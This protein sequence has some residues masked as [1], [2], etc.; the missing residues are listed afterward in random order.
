MKKIDEAKE[1]LK[2]FGL[3][4]SQ[5]NDIS[6]FTLLALCNLRPTDNWIKASKTSLKITK[7]IM[8]FVKAVYKK[9]YA[10]NTRETFRRQVLHQFVQA[11]IA[12]YNPDNLN[13][14]VNSPN[15]HYALTDSAL[16]VI[17]S[18]KS[19]NWNKEFKK[20]NST[21]ESLLKDY[22]KSRK[23]TLIPVKLSNG[24]TLKLSA[25]KHN[26]VQEAVIRLFATRFAPKSE[27]IYIGD[28]ALKDLY[29]DEKLLKKLNIPIN[30]HSKL[31]DIIIYNSKNNWIYLIEAVTSHGPISPKR[32]Y[33]LE[34]L[35]K[36]CNSA[37]IFVTAF[38][39]FSEFKKHTTNIAWETEV[40]IVDF[41]DH[42][43]HF[44]GDRF[45][46]PR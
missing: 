45:F 39:D 40:W 31:P 21:K 30:K 14:P 19:K 4:I 9:N 15:A 11:R 10:P 42:L 13:L 25:G 24:K 29:M 27:V 26:I 36:D 12:D 1:I 22:N 38:P 33:E 37:K 43:I 41:P 3:P 34:E 23:K 20:F 8:K 7:G 2:A 18:F 5:Q 16:S 46:G 32:L 6:A 17:K 28:T 35:L 44:N